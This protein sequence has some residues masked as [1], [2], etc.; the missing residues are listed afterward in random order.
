[1]KET[2]Y[3]KGYE[4]TKRTNIQVGNLGTINEVPQD[5]QPDEINKLIDK[6]VSLY[7][8]QKFQGFRTIVYES[9]L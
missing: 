8:T 2:R 6:F 4:I 3:Y 7:E 1:M 9:L 5:L